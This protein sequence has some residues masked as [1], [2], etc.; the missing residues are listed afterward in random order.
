MADFS[1]EDF[2]A[3]VKCVSKRF[4]IEKF[5]EV[6]QEA[7]LNLLKGKTERYSATDAKHC[8]L[9]NVNDDFVFGF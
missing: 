6:Q 3:A 9:I 2:S 8:S 1:S 7:L 4:H 5:R